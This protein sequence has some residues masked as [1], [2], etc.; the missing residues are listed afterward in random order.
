MESNNI[1]SAIGFSYVI[2]RF[3]WTDGAWIK[4]PLLGWKRG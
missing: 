4:W 3:N 1:G 2:Y